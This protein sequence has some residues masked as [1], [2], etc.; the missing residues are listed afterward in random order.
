MPERDLN[1]P[2]T[3][4]NR[5]EVKD[6][7][8]EFEREFRAHSEFLRGR[9]D[10]D[11]LVTVGLVDDPRVYVHLGHWRSLRGFQDTVRDDT[12][13]AQVR[14]LG[15]KVHTAADQ[16]VSVQRTLHEAAAVGSAGVVLFGARVHGECAELEKRFAV[17][18]DRCHAAGGFGGSDL[19]RS[20]VRPRSYTGVLWWRDAEHC[21]RTRAGES[22]RQAL[23]AL[24]E[25]ADVTVEHSRHVAYERAHERS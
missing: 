9:A 2:V 12:F 20:I 17:L 4:I 24:R 22:W 16:A 13:T 3:V 8:K 11:F 19:L 5:F 25:I 10:F 18:N 6:D 15:A 21:A 1:S 14:R 23:Q 7:V